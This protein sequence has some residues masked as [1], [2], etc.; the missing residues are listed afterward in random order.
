MEIGKTWIVVELGE[1]S[2]DEESFPQCR[3]TTL[4]K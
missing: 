1:S 2:V 3:L 4:W